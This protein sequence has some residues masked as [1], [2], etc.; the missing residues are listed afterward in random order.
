MATFDISIALSLLSLSLICLLFRSK[1]TN[2]LT[3]WPL[4]RHAVPFIMLTSSGAHDY[5]TYLLAQSG[6]T[7]QL[8]GPSFTNLRHIITSD[9]ENIS[10]ILSSNSSNYNKGPGFKKKF[11]IWGDGILAADS[12]SWKFQRRL[13]HS[14]FRGTDFLRMVTA[15]ARR[16]LEDGV[17][18]ILDRAADLGHQ[19]DLRDLFQR[20]TIEI[21][22]KFL[23]GIDLNSLEIN[24]PEVPF[25]KAFDE[26]KEVIYSRCI[27]PE[28]FW[29]LQKWLKIGVEGKAGKASEI[30]N[31][32]IYQQIA[33]KRESLR[34]GP[35]E[36]DVSL[37]M[38]SRFMAVEDEASQC[39]ADSETTSMPISDMFL[40]D[41]VVNVLS[42]G[43]DPTSAA[44][45][46]FFLLVSTHEPVERKIREELKAAL[47]IKEGEK[48]QFPS[49]QDIDKLVYLHAA[50]CETLRL[51][52][53][54]P[55]NYREAIRPDTLPSG[56]H[57]E[58]NATI[59]IPFY[60]QGRTESLWGADCLEF[61]PERW[62]SEKGE[63]VHMGCGKF[64]AFSAGP[65]SCLGKD[66][67]LM[68]LKLAVTAI[69]WSYH[70]EVVE[71]HSVVPANSIG[72]YPKHG[73][74]IRVIK[75]SGA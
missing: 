66:L 64:T 31:D 68:E 23:L 73:L 52:P 45:T 6:H 57:V 33:S 30:I 29:R 15:T 41:S 26:Y 19:V 61:K 20:F 50:I 53:P 27:R 7:T 25:A 43:R 39:Q 34:K 36:D 21:T 51:Y 28:G 48:W 24:L 60:A 18:P 17:F 54:I 38:I 10:H 42:A 9:P 56:Q 75:N 11:E 46:W 5:M 3:C 59:L 71:G 55:I 65:R 40:R 37:D 4:I 12:D 63:I 8:K 13:N 32:F 44:L 2:P 69:M 74:K 35:Q 1:I 72:L 47:G 49:F 58:K 70:F 14:L 62:I 16:K 22:C 67:A